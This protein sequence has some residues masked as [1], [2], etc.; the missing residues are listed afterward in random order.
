MS[1]PL[2]LL[3]LCA[4]A[5]NPYAHITA[6]HSTPPRDAS[7]FRGVA[8]NAHAGINITDEGAAPTPAAGVALR[9]RVAARQGQI[10]LGP[11][12]MGRLL[13]HTH[14]DG[15]SGDWLL[16]PMELYGRA[17]LS[18]FGAGALEGAF[19]ASA[20]SPSGEVGLVLMQGH[21]DVPYYTLSAAIERDVRWGAAPDQTF[22]SVLLGV[23][24]LKVVDRRGRGGF[25]MR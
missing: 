15:T 24:F 9:S 2:A 5:C 19:S 3:S 18:L 6:G 1:K 23:G 22:V 21:E 4:A 12:V 7:G 20:F 14:N 10:A 8:V 13:F 25:V 11:E 17:G 16:T